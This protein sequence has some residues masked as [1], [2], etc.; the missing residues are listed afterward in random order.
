MMSESVSM[1]KELSVFMCIKKNLTKRESER[2]RVNIS[3]KSY[4]RRLGYRVTQSPFRVKQDILQTHTH[5]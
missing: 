5:L 1:R 4:R 3:I 2:G